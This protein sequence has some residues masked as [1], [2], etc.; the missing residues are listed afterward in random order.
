[1]LT[2]LIV[3]LLGDWSASFLSVVVD[4][5]SYLQKEL[6]SSSSSAITRV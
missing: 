1:M 4:I 2:F 6:L 5:M 3:H